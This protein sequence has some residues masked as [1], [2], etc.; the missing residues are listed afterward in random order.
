MSLML[1]EKRPTKILAPLARYGPE[2]IFTSNLTGLPVP[3]AQTL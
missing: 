3:F 2:N 1:Y